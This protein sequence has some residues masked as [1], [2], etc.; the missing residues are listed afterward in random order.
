VHN[1]KRLTT[2]DQDE[3]T[4]AVDDLLTGDYK[5]LKTK[6]ARPLKIVGDNIRTVICAAPGNVLIGADFSGIEARVTAWLAG[7]V[8]KLQVFR[9]YDAGKG[10]D[11]YVAAAGDVFGLTSAQMEALKKSD[12]AE[13]KIKRQGGKGAELAFG[14]QGGV[15]AFIKFVPEGLFTNEQVDEFKVKWR[16][17]HGAIVQMWHNLNRSS[18]RVSKGAALLGRKVKQ[19]TPR[20]AVGPLMLEYESGYMF[21]VLPSGRRISYPGINRTKDDRERFNIQKPTDTDLSTRKMSVYFMDNS[22]GRWHRVFSYGGLLMENVVQGVARDLLAAA[23]LRIEAAGLPIVVHVHD[24]CVIEVPKKSAKKVMTEFTRLM[25]ELPEWASRDKPKNAL[26]V[27]AKGW[28]S[29][30]YVK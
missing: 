24:E 9:D 13:F 2:E 12:P 20:E 28:I 25:C 17:S 16:K 18:Y 30:R 10:P 1:L 23:M 22:S 8:R 26:P 27:V 4:G 3:I 14:F 29:E 5:V 6:Y 7:E 21:I 19:S 15:N 11:P